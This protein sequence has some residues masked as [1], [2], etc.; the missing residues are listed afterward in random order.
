MLLLFYLSQ[1]LHKMKLPVSAD[2]IISADKYKYKYLPLSLGFDR[3]AMMTWNAAE[4]PEQALTCQPY[5][6]A[7]GLPVY[8]DS[9]DTHL[10]LF[11]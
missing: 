9:K 5:W 3:A 6:Q 11:P 2:I 4:G 1:N 8:L 10:H 7:V